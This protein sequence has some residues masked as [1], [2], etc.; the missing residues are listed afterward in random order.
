MLFRT[1]GTIIIKL[2]LMEL[3]LFPTDIAG[4]GIEQHNRPLIGLDLPCPS[5]DSWGFSRQQLF[6]RDG[7]TKNIGAGIKR[8]VQDRENSATGQTPPDQLT[9]I[10][11]APETSRKPQLMF[12]EVRHNG[13]GRRVLCEQIKNQPNGSLDFLIRV[14]D[15][16]ACRGVD[17]PNGWAKVQ[18]SFLGLGQFA[19]EQSLTQPM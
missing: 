10:R 1:P 14:D 7:P 11:P 17:Q 8:V 9:V 13:E 18:V 16:L 19:D 15:D 4:M 3:K 12:G 5:F 2:L 6:A